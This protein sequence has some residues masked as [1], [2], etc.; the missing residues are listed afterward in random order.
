MWYVIIQSW[1]INGDFVKPPLKLRLERVIDSILYVHVI[2]NPCPRL[3]YSV[4]SLVKEAQC[5]IFIKNCLHVL[6]PT[7]KDNNSR[8]RVLLLLF[9][10][11][12]FRTCLTSYFT[13]HL[14]G[15]F[16]KPKRV[17]L[18]IFTAESL[19][20]ACPLRH[21]NEQYVI[22]NRI[23]SGITVPSYKRH[24]V[25]NHRQ[26]D[27]LLFIMVPCVHEHRFEHLHACTS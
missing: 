17:W 1:L 10:W 15:H 9:L 20:G 18:Y 16:H 27:C 19:V 25:F 13:D 14:Y 2:T 6:N 11:V 23:F 5:T 7:H 21:L 24:D 4:S 8:T 12:G 26:F 22:E 3:W